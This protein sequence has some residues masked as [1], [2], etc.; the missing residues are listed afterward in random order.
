M[1]GVPSLHF[2]INSLEQGIKSLDKNL[3][4]WHSVWVRGGD[5][6]EDVIMAVRDSAHIMGLSQAD[7][8]VAEAEKVA[9]IALE[10]GYSADVALDLARPILQRGLAS[11]A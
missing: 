11:A 2:R 10:E 4:V 8:R 9:R 1:R 3:W 5:P 6:M 7:P